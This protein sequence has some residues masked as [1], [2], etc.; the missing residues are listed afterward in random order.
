M[1]QI[2][3]RIE[4]DGPRPTR[5]VPVKGQQHTSRGEAGDA[6]RGIVGRAL[7]DAKAGGQPRTPR[8]RIVPVVETCAVMQ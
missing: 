1:W 6:L 3:Q 7:R 2:E 8:F 5:W 4:S